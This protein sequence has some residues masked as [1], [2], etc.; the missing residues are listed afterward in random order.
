MTVADI[1][2]RA[3][4]DD[5]IDPEFKEIAEPPRKILRVRLSC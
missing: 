4:K 5:E 3:L 2:E 1:S